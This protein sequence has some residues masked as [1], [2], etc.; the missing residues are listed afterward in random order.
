MSIHIF[1]EAA[2]ADDNSMLGWFVLGAFVWI[3]LVVMFVKSLHH[4][5]E[6]RRLQLFSIF[7]LA[8]GGLIWWTK[9]RPKEGQD[10][11]QH[12]GVRE[13]RRVSRRSR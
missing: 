8:V 6:R 3:V 10:D 4:S 2:T 12:A 11:S 1:A 9:T 5:A 7:A 13:Y